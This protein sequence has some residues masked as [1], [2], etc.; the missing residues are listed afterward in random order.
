M[1]TF[2]TLVLKDVIKNPSSSFQTLKVYLGV[3][4]NALP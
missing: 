1:K 4:L 3:S 2:L